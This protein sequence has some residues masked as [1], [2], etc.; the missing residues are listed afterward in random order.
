MK[1]QKML[2]WLTVVNLV[3]L[4]VQLASVP[5]WASPDILRGRALE[6]VD[7]QGRVR[8]SLGIL[9]AAPADGTSAG[10]PIPET[11]ILRLMNTEGRPAV[12]VSTSDE[13]SGV[14]FTGDARTHETYVSLGSSG[15]TSMLKLKNEDG[16]E[17]ILKP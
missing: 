8:A 16:R 11:V 3:M 9:P 4:V 5:A 2:V 17:Q 10:R 7:A 1:A 13:G 12:K 6:I 15:R 14:S